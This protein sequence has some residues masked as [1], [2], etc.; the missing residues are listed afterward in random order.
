[1]E[2]LMARV[3][4]LDAERIYMGLGDPVPAAEVQ[5]G[6]FVFGDP[7]LREALPEGAIWVERD[8]DLPPAKYRLAEPHGDHPF[9]HF[10]PANDALIQEVDN[11]IELGLAMALAS[12]NTP[13]PIGR[14]A[15]QFYGMA[16][17][18]FP[19]IVKRH[20]AK[21]SR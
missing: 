13:G 9:W 6:D 14:Y 16:A 3:A 20:A 1:M 21:G 4:R 19:D 18:N 15:Q 10:V 2:A 7:A 11:M 5:A 8:C 17:K 12:W